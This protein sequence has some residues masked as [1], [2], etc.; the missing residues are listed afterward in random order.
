MFNDLVYIYNIDRDVDV[1]SKCIYVPMHV[2][3]LNLLRDA[4]A[5]ATLAQAFIR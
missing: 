5:Y 2:Q 1:K 3:Y 4:S